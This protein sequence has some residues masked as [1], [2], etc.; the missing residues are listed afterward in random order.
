ML[1][2]DESA[3]RLDGYMDSAGVLWHCYKYKAS[4]IRCDSCVC[5][6]SIFSWL[7]GGLDFD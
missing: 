1:S 7:F 2:I 5:G 3:L 4:C 6:L